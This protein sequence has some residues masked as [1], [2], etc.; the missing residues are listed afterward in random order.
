MSSLMSDEVKDKTKQDGDNV[1][2]DETKTDTESKE[3]QAKEPKSVS[4]N[5]DVHVK[6]FGK[7][8]DDVDHILIDFTVTVANNTLIYHLTVM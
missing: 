6:R 4:F 1:A 2:K 7:K 3:V 8:I 5:R